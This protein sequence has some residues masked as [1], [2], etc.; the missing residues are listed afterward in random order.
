M[1]CDKNTCRTCKQIANFRSFKRL[2]PNPVKASFEE[3]FNEIYGDLE[4][5]QMDYATSLPEWRQDNPRYA[6][7]SEERYQLRLKEWKEQNE[8]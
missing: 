2:L 4:M 8:H 1:A 7:E 6:D 3:W 5:A